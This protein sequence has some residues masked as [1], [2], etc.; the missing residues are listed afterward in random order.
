MMIYAAAA[1]AVLALGACSKSDSG[2]SDPTTPTTPTDP[3]K[4][5][6]AFTTHVEAMSGSTAED[7]L[8]AGDTFTLVAYDA[9]KNSKSM[10]YTLGA[11]AL[12]WEELSF[13]AEGSTVNFAACYP[14]Q[15]LTDGGF[16]F[17]V[18][19]DAA[20]DLLWASKAGVSAGSEQAVDLTFSHALHRLVVKYTVDDPSIDASQIETTCTALA[21]CRVDLLEQRLLQGDTRESYTARGGQVEFLLLPQQ[22][23]GVSLEI[24]AGEAS[25]SWKLSET[26]FSYPEL[27]SGKQVTVQLTIK[28]GQ[29]TLSGMTIAGWGNQG[30]IED[31]IEM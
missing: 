29:V 9:E 31:E 7:A 15:A 16:D 27:E 20:S 30:T 18:R 28:N 17:T 8:A 24:K 13:A 12:Y 4:T 3:D 11:S 19:Q 14:K 6:V 2:Q 10:D 22:T 5:P 1:A 21:S 26:D 23:D 25:K